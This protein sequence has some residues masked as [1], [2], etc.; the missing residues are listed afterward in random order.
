[1]IKLYYYLLAALAALALVTADAYA[2]NDAAYPNTLVDAACTDSYDSV[3]LTLLG[4]GSPGVEDSGSP[5]NLC[6]HDNRIVTN[7]ITADTEFGPLTLPEGTSCIVVFADAEIVSND[8]DT[9]NFQIRM[10]KPH[11]GTKYAVFNDG[12][13]AT[14]GSHILSYCPATIVADGP[15]TDND[16]VVPRTFYI[17]FNLASATSWEGDISWVAY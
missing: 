6:D 12:T 13:I 14:E 8:I 10:V 4:W 7:A 17:Y 5:N 9:W 11:N 1:M 3:G 16:T 15:G 2:A